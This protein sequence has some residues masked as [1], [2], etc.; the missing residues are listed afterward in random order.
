[1]SFLTKYTY[2][3]L[4][5][6]KI[7]HLEQKRCW[8]WYGCKDYLLINKMTLENCRKQGSKLGTAWINYRKGFD[9]LPYFCTLK[10]F[11]IYKVSSVIS[12]F[13]KY[14]MEL[15][16]TKGTAISKCLNIRRGIFQGDSMS[17]FLF[18]VI[19]SPIHMN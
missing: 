3:F 16:H 1:M 15:N 8:S 10:A 14:D 11:N 12:N 17:S 6:N 18:S 2:P 19:F 13:L 4:D 9:S 7:F 5:E